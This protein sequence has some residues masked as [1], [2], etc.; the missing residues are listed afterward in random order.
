MVLEKQLS[1]LW[2]CTLVCISGEREQG[3]VCAYTLMSKVENEVSSFPM[4]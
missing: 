1:R 3:S 2:W 4:G